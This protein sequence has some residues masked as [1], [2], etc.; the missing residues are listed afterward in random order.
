MGFTL[1]IAEKPSVAR[2]L[3]KVLNC[4]QNANGYIMGKKY[5]VTWALGH[6]VTLADPEAYGNKYKTWNLEDLPM[7]PNKMELV[8]IKQT[9]K[10]YGVVR[11]LLNRADVDEL[12]IAT[13]SGREGE[14]VARWIIMKAGFKKPTKRLWISSQ[15]DKAIKEGFAKLRPSN[16]YDN[17]YYSAQSRAE[18][19]WLVGLNVTRALTCKYNAQLSAGR[20]QTPTLAMIVERE[21][22]IR[23]FRPKDY[24]TI[25]AQFNG[26]SVQWQDS[27]T[28]QTRT[29]NKEEADG[30]VA[31]ITGQMGEVVEVKK[32][33][34]KELPPLAYDL[35]ELQRDANKKFSYSAKQTLNIMQRLY[36]S[37]KL[38]TYP[39]TDSRYITD[40]IVPT[41]NERLKSIAVGPYAKLVQ[42]VMRNRISVT[43]R[44]VDN[45]KVTDHHAIIP[46][47]QFVDLS[48]LNPEERNIYD[49][50][51]K[52]FIAILS[53]PFE[54]EQTT[55]KLDVAGESFYAKGKIVRSSG[56]K[57][58]YDGF[59][60]L[61]E[62]SDE[63]DNDQ[64]LP[65][66]QKGYKAK[67]VAPKAINGKTKPPAR[68]TEATLLS[69]MEHPGKFVDNKALKEALEN[70]SG[71]GTPATRADI[72]EKLFNTFYI[73]RRGK[74]IYPTS[75]GTQLISLVPA[76]LKSPELT[77]KWEQQLSLI[78]KGKVNSN[79]FVGEMKN[80]AKKLVGAV[81][82]S[83]EQF[84]HDNVTR[85]KC[86][87]CGKY[88]LEVN[89]KKGKMHVCPDRECGYRKSVTVI[90]NARCPECHKKMEIRGEGE[91][92]SFYC[93][94]GY[95]EKLDAFKKRKGEQVDKKDVA[96]FMRQQEKDES[97]N[98]ALADALAK[99]KK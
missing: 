49:L 3:A 79:A 18:A 75:K 63:D 43:K 57:T 4:G 17:L 5:I 21:E 73:E 34:K 92:K 44:F 97:I 25:S 59:G 45:S 61:D 74:E 53:Q 6:L 13:D 82:A 28:N 42:G 26:F 90:S 72:I 32:E 69:A 1:V 71:L 8:V 15:T 83:S 40:D 94:C 58:V 31:K 35:T 46:T 93:S 48:S 23:K 89:G 37:H 77:A 86:P 52:R 84:K 67:V 98:S 54:Y 51:V 22:E 87:E 47:E 11:G 30:I 19:D 95:R 14:L 88:L 2:D 41:L 70:T 38:V 12:V 20:V 80:Y 66:I 60:K 27:R 64:S 55:V 68:Y 36:E 9:A 10:Q 78:S 65:D 99:W 96:R 50:I 62:D 56:W 33:T 24:W 7:L 16:E 39:R 91:N 81:I 29:F 76:D 85:E